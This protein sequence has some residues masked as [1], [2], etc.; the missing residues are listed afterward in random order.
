VGA[1]P[2]AR[3]ILSCFLRD[4]LYPGIR[5]KK[6]RE[7]FYLC[8]KDGKVSGF[9]PEVGAKLKIASRSKGGEELYPGGVSQGEK[10]RSLFGKKFSNR[11]IIRTLTKS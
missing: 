9:L 5:D 4:Q 6:G 7:G 1:P 11:D 2:R 3:C 8:L 10:N